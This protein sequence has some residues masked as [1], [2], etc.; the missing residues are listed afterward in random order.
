MIPILTTHVS[1]LH[2]T[3]QCQTT[4]CVSLVIFIHKILIVLPVGAV[5][6]SDPADNNTIR[7]HLPW[8]VKRSDGVSRNQVAILL[9]VDW[10][11]P[12]TSGLKVPFDL[13]SGS[14][15]KWE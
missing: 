10:C 6:A 8:I 9:D 15:M 2:Q 13:P 12:H 5:S 14:G 7:L 3:C 1:D 11:D 4:L